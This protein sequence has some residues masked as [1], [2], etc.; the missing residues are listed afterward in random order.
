MQFLLIL[1]C[2]FNFYYFSSSVQISTTVQNILLKPSSSLTVTNKVSHSYRIEDRTVLGILSLFPLKRE[3]RL[4]L[5]PFC[6]S[7]CPPPITFE[8][9]SLTS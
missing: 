9:T 1:P 5:S 7:V 8:P 4:M 6:L 2:S 3:L